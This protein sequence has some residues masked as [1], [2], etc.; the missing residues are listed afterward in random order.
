MKKQD[1]KNLS[2]PVFK[3]ESFD[4]M[5]GCYPDDSD[6]EC[7]NCCALENAKILI[8]QGGPIASLLK[9]VTIIQDGKISWARKI[10]E[11][12]YCYKKLSGP[13]FKPKNFLITYRGEIALANSI[14]FFKLLENI[15]SYRWHVFTILSKHP[16]LLYKK[17]TPAI[18]YMDKMGI[19][20]AKL[21]NLSIGTSVGINKYKYR[22]DELR[23]FE[24][25][26]LELWCKPLLEYLYNLN[27]KGIN[28][29]RISAEKG[30]YKRK[31]KQEW[32]DGIT[33]SAVKQ[34][35]NIYYDKD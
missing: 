23:K 18:K 34:G 25:F 10:I 3:Y 29:V 9:K 16:A 22:I 1:F 35:A 19:K 24:G 20:V 33:R 14:I 5:F 7:D 32:I 30:K 4:P 31:C 27:L 12:P 6:P 2:R 15:Y 17:M 8:G 28:S 13:N 11:N 21:K 26:D